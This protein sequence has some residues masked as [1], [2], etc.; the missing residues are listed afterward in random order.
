MLSLRKKKKNHVI[1]LVFC[2]SLLEKGSLAYGMPDPWLV[3]N[4]PMLVT[5]ATCAFYD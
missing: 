5:G 1:R 4:K 3:S 2:I